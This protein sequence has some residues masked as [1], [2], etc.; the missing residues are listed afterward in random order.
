MHFN[1]FGIRLILLEYSNTLDVRCTLMKNMLTSSTNNEIKMRS[2]CI[3]VKID[4]KE[5]AIMTHWNLWKNI[6]QLFLQ[7]SPV[8]RGQIRKNQL[9]KQNPKQFCQPVFMLTTAYTPKY[10]HVYST[11]GTTS[12]CLE[13]HA[14]IRRKTCTHAYRLTHT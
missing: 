6:I 10:I 8:L 3:P 11:E 13:K 1:G 2:E 14:R 9:I 5:A 4:T 12:L 7:I